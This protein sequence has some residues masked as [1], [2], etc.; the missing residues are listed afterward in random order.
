MRLYGIKNIFVHR[1][2]GKIQGV[3][4]LNINLLAKTHS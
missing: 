1:P 2:P 4:V 3:I